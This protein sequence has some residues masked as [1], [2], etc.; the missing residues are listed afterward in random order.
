M[1]YFWQYTHS[2]RYVNFLVLWASV[3]IFQCHLDIAFDM[4]FIYAWYGSEWSFLAVQ[5]CYIFSALVLKHIR[6]SGAIHFTFD[7]FPSFSFA[8]LLYFFF[9]LWWVLQPI[10]QA[11][12]VNGIL[13]Y[14]PK[15]AAHTNY[16]ISVLV[17][18]VFLYLKQTTSKKIAH[19]LFSN[20][21]LL[22]LLFVFQLCNLLSLN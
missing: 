20:F 12:F 9:F 3:N 11:H 16:F 21:F 2:T 22:L 17:A 8:S 14:L 4:T 10:S 5:M 6:F 19:D 18:V 15:W 1:F 13:F 7:E